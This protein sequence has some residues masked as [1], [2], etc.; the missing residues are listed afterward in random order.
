MI[1]VKTMTLVVGGLGYVFMLQDTRINKMGMFDYI[2]YQGKQYQTKNTPAQRLASY[3][4]KEDGTLWL[5]DVSPF[6]REFNLPIFLSNFTEQIIFYDD[7]P[8]WIEWNAT[9]VKGKLMR[10]EEVKQ[11]E[12]DILLNTLDEDCRKVVKDFLN[13]TIKEVQLD[14]ENNKLVFNFTSGIGFY[15][16]DDGQKCCEQRYM[17]TDDNLSDYN[18]AKLVDIELKDS[19]IT[20]ENY[21]VHAIQFLEVSTSKGSFQMAN[22]NVHNGYYGG[23]AIRACYL[24]N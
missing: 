18:H 8:E 5:I 22:H 17:T 21:D 11:E 1:V 13:K 12:N 9:F 24:K 2:N 7:T 14:E 15:L 19:S 6:N 20:D 16:W 23:F 10:I 3:E 4:I